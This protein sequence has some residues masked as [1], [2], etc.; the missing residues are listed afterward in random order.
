MNLSDTSSDKN[1]NFL[2]LILTGII[3]LI[4]L[5]SFRL[6]KASSDEKLEIEC[7]FSRNTP[8]GFGVLPYLSEKDLQEQLGCIADFLSKNLE[9]PVK[10]NIAAD[11][12]TLGNLLD[13]DKVQIAW[14]SN[15]SYEHYRRGD[16]WEVLCRPM[17]D[18]KVYHQG[19]ILCRENSDIKSVNDLKGKKF[20]Y[21]DRNSGTGFVYANRFFRNNGIEPIKFFGEIA[22][23]GNHSYSFDG[24]LNKEYDGIAVFNNNYFNESGEIASGTSFS[25]LRLLGMTPKILNDP[26]IV[27]KNLK[28]DL[29][30]KLRNLM[31]NMMKFPKGPETLAKLIKSRNYDRFASEEEVQKVFSGEE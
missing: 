8:M 30:E 14:F 20:A 18:G 27:R 28:P 16:S 17:R 22:F 7:L 1:K 13:L 11:Y 25:G 19:V 2:F 3:L 15:S 12:S 6:L 31:I 21:V 29:K 23:S 5:I 24:L 10:I 4:C 26:L 9:R